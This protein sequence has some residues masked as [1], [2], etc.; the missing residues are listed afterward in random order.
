[1]TVFRRYAL[2]AMAEEPLHTIASQW[3]GWDSRLGHKVDHPVLE[4]LRYDIAQATATPRKY[5]FHGTL[6]P[7]FRLIEG[8]SRQQLL[9]ACQERLPTMQSVAI[10][11]MVVRPMNGFVALVPEGSCPALDQLCERVVRDF[12]AFRA[13]LNGAELA[14]R[15]ASKLTDRQEEQLLRWGYPYVMD[16]FRFHMTLSG[17][18][19]EETSHDLAER[20]QRYLCSD[21]PEPFILR[22]I[23]LMGEDV[24]GHFHEIEAYTLAA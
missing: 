15:R 10:S 9:R 24:D 22:T 12:D 20:L 13:P 18:L 6:K 19:D 5:G 17:Q 16:E 7:P 2:Y 21:M 14:K 8:Q 23:S 4:G 1:M 11:R 3:L